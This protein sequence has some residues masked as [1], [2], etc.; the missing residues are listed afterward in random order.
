MGYNSQLVRPSE[1]G[2]SS[3]AEAAGGVECYHVT[4]GSRWA[5]GDDELSGVGR[6]ETTPHLE[7]Q[8]VLASGHSF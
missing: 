3:A 4:H 1:L 6:G 5:P 2:S 7:R 8:P